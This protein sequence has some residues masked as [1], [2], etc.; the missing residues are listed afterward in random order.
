MALR[1][2][3]LNATALDATALSATVLIAAPAGASK[4]L[5]VFEA[6]RPVA[7]HPP[8]APHRLAAQRWPRLPGCCS[9][10]LTQAA[11]CGDGGRA[12]SSAVTNPPAT[13]QHPPAST[14]TTAAIT[15]CSNP[16]FCF[17]LQCFQDLGSFGVG[18]C[19]FFFPLV[20]LRWKSPA[21]EL[22]VPSSPIR[23]RN[24]IQS[25]DAATGC[26]EA[27]LFLFFFC[28]LFPSP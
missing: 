16:I 27:L 25:K 5:G 2:T 10:L 12:T 7:A 22:A 20:W 6:P 21:W 8:S 28:L 24:L 13:T 26:A 1:A 4:R 11:G 9:I 23:Q 3:A 14:L 15:T 17:V 18:V 19:F